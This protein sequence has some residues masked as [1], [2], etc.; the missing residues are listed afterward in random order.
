MTGFGYSVQLSEMGLAMWIVSDILDLYVTFYKYSFFI[1]ASSIVPNGTLVSLFIELLFILHLCQREDY[2][3]S[4]NLKEEKYSGR[5]VFKYVGSFIIRSCVLS[6][7]YDN[8]DM[9]FTFES[10]V[11]FLISI[12]LLSTILYMILPLCLGVLYYCFNLNV[13]TAK[14]RQVARSMKSNISL[15][16]SG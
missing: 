4:H 9:S 14:F 8:T 13:L 16:C 6:M 11:H 7:C 3:L 1:I 15:I 2:H 12:P 10:M 5:Q